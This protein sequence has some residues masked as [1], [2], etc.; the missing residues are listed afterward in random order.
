MPRPAVTSL[1]SDW[2]SA[3]SAK[4][5]RD[6]T[7]GTNGATKTYS[8]R[9]RPSL[10]PAYSLDSGGEPELIVAVVE[11]GVVLAEEDI[12]KDPQ[13]AARCWDIETREAKEA[14]RHTALGDLEYVVRALELELLAADREGERGELIN[15]AALDLPLL[16]AWHLDRARELLHQCR[17]LSSRE[18]EKRCTRVGNRLDVRGE[19]STTNRDLAHAELP[20]ALDRDGCVRELPGVLG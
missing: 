18:R 8:Q 11:N 7:D 12:A 17:D 13:R 10:R 3:S 2:S 20:I 6:T 19:I 16:R 4:H 15:L 9:K 1:L 5:T 14:L